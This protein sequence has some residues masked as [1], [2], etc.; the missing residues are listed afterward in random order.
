MNIPINPVLQKK[1]TAI[2]QWQP[3]AGRAYSNP[4][5]GLGVFTGNEADIFDT[6]G[7]LYGYRKW[8]VCSLPG[9]TRVFNGGKI[10]ITWAMKKP[11]L[12]GLYRG[13]Y[14]PGI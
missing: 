13:L 10:I 6:A 2:R 8:R 4:S 5:Q 7:G 3:I 1:P 11:W 12:V 14:Y 9:P